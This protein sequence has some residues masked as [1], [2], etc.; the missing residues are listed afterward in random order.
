VTLYEVTLQV[1]PALVSALD[2]HMRDQHIP[3][4]FATGCFRRIRFDQASPVRFRTCYEAESGADLDRYLRQHA[5]GFRAEFQAAFP[6]GVIV[7]RETWT[8][9]KRWE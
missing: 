8:E 1:E 7:T 6:H 2:N 3:A 5:P 4:I 9:R